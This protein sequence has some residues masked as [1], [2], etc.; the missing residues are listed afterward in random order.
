VFFIYMG[1]FFHLSLLLTMSG[2]G[3]KKQQS[4]TRVSLFLRVIYEKAYLVEH[5]L[6]W[7]QLPISGNIHIHTSAQNNNTYT[8]AHTFKTPFGSLIHSVL[9][10]F[11]L[12]LYFALSS[13]VPMRLSFCVSIY[14]SVSLPNLSGAVCTCTSIYILK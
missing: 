13:Y 9:P 14:L 8:Y 3:R 5:S 10:P 6:F 2:S 12:P 11:C 1:M 4:V 7:M